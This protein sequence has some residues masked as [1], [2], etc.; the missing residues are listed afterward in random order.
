MKT[1]LAL[2][3]IAIGGWLIYSGYQLQESASGSWSTFS[4]KVATSVDGKTRVAQHIWYYVGGGVLVLAGLGT[5]AS[6]RKK[7]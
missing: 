1:I 3:L 6:S 5:L 7:S 2:I 4:N